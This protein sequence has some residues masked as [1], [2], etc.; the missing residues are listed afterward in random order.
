MAQHDRMAQHHRGPVWHS[1]VVVQ[2]GTASSWHSRVQWG[3]TCRSVLD[4]SS[5]L[6]NSGCHP[7]HT[8]PAPLG[9]PCPRVARP[10]HTPS[11]IGTHH[12]HPSSASIIKGSPHNASKCTTAHRALAVR[13]RRHRALTTHRVP[14]IIE[15]ASQ[16]DISCAVRGPPTPETGAVL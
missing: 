10:Q 11:I 14:G 5:S 15:H 6:L 2:C 8:Q 16:L 4:Q 12:R 7:K 1:M 13:H 3:P 9:A